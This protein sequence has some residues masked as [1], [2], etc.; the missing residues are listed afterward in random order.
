MYL[1]TYVLYRLCL[2]FSYLILILPYFLLLQR[3]KGQTIFPHYSAESAAE[4]A[5]EQWRVSG[6]E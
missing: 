2:L 6:H 5:L 1:I 3:W 4:T